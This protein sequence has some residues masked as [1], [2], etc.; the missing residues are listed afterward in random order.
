MTRRLSIVASPTVDRFIRSAA[1]CAILRGPRGEGKSTGGLLK[2]MAG[3]A[4]LSPEAL[5][6]RAVCLRDTLVTLRDTL[7]QTVHELEALGLAA[8]WHHDS[9]HESA[10]TLGYRGSGT[11]RPG[12]DGLVYLRLLGLDRMAE[13]NK[14]QGLGVGCVWLEEPAPAAELSGGIPPEVFGVAATSLRQPGVSGWIQMT[15]NPPDV[16]HWT[17]TV[18]QRLRELA[19]ELPGGRRVTVEVFDIPKGENRH[20]DEEQRL[21]NRLALEATGRADLV[22]RLIEGRVGQILVGE[23]VMPEY[24]DELHVAPAPL[25]ILPYEPIVRA[26]DFGLTPV[27]IWTQVTPLGRWRL[28]WG[29]Q[30]QNEGIAQLIETRV[31]PWEA[32]FLEGHEGGSRNLGDAAGRQREQS[33]AEHSAAAVVEDLLGAPFEAGPIAWPDRRDS[34]KAVLSRMSRGTPVVE[35][36]PDNLLVRRA[37]RGGWHYPKDALG[38]ITPTLEAAKRASGLHDHVGHAIAHGASILFPV[39][40][41]RYEPPRR[42]APTPVALGGRPDLAWMAV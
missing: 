34:L 22:Q 6:L 20:Y 10:V 2:L 29:V 4:A 8:H 16:E 5:P 11:P 21:H 27:C 38:R 33:N 37:L 26:F 7:V 13:V 3:A 25:P 9:G 24:N 28:I 32:E 19:A 18:A 17:I 42:S 31:Q 36:D 39:T 14:L 23:P 30:G 40:Q 15:M 1:Y 12:R 35:V 41:A